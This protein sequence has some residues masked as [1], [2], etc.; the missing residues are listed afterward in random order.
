MS[1]TTKQSS[2]K[3]SSRS[4][5]RRD[6]LEHRTSGM[7]TERDK[8]SGL[9]PRYSEMASTISRQWYMTNGFI[10]NIIDA[11]AEDATREWITIKTNRDNDDPNTGMKG[12]GISRIIMNRF[13]ELGLRAKIK[14]LIRFSRLYQNGGFLFWGITANA[15]QNDLELGKQMS[16]DILKL[17]YINVFGPDR[18]TLTHQTDDPL[19]RDYH[20][21]QFQVSSNTIHPSRLSWM[22]HSYLPEERRGVSVLDTI[23]D[24]IRAQDVGLWSVTSLLFEMSVK[25][26]KS[27]AVAGTDPKKLIE[28]LAEMQSVMN[29]QGGVALDEGET[30]ERLDSNSSQNGQI[31]QVFDFIF[32]NLSGQ[33]RIPKSRLMGNAQGVIT[34]G[35]FDLVSYYDNV[36]KFQELEVRPI[37]EKAISLVVHETQG[38]IK[39]LLGADVDKLDW[40]FD[41][42]PLWKLGPVEQADVDLKQAQYDQIYITTAV[43]SPSEVKSK[44]FADLEQHTKWEKAP[45]NMSKPSITAL[46]GGKSEK[47]KEPGRKDGNGE[48]DTEQ[49]GERN[50]A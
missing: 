8:L 24:G 1:R 45:I 12:L 19:S 47:D 27:P 43:L 2:K 13:D 33:S 20:V 36:A 14:D 35:Q 6:S 46:L 40:E 11:P 31:K 4:S 25:V 48:P 5:S 16:T 38:E 28:F 23:L 29:T 44:R 3:G 9:N 34:A 26:F 49:S 15:P 21:Q 18:V 17:D 37:I 30:L 50:S 7:G 41:F 32:D 42:N 10:Q 39:K 22:V